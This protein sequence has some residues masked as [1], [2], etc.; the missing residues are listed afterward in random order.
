M[1]CLKIMYHFRRGGG[2]VGVRTIHT[3]IHRTKLLSL[4]CVLRQYHYVKDGDV[5]ENLGHLSTYC[6]S[7]I[8]L[9]SVSDLFFHDS[10]VEQ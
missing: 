8:H 4:D 7:Q 5:T 2:K 3:Q 9:K 10:N 1:N 6:L